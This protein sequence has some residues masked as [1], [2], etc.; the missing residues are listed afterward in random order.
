MIDQDSPIL[1]GASPDLCG[2]LECS[3]QPQVSGKA[4]SIRQSDLDIPP[5]A[6]NVNEIAARLVSPTGNFQARNLF[7]YR[8]GQS[9]YLAASL[10]YPQETHQKSSSG[11]T[12]SPLLHRNPGTLGHSD[13][14]TFDAYYS[15]TDM[16]EIG[17]LYALAMRGRGVSHHASQRNFCSKMLLC[18]VRSMTHSHTSSRRNGGMASQSV[19]GVVSCLCMAH[20]AINDKQKGKVLAGLTRRRKAE[21]EMYAA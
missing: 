18:H 13:Y 15:K 21:A 4:R 5:S 1:I 19:E 14:C 10:P 17:R 2:K 20:F 11:Y 9:S 16:S 3:G 6:R 7:R 12:R 8:S